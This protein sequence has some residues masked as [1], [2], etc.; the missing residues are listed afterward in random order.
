M[1]RHALG[2]PATLLTSADV[3][4]HLDGR[5]R[6]ASLAL[7]IAKRKPM[8]FPTKDVRPAAFMSRYGAI[9]QAG[10]SLKNLC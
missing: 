2:L 5:K 4:S 1:T 9:R 7:Y 6:G 10:T 3:V 8:K